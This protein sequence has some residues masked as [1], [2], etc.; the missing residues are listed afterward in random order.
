[1]WGRSSRASNAARLYVF[2]LVAMLATSAVACSKGGNGSNRRGDPVRVAAASDL[3]IAFKEVG[4]AF[5]QATGKKVDFSFGSTGLL[6]KQIAEGAPFDVFA[7]ANVSYVEDV[8]KASACFGDTKRVYAR[9]RLVIWSKD[10]ALLPATI[11]DLKDPKYAK[12]AIANPDHAPYGVAAQQALTKAGVWATVQP[13]VV[14]GENV[15]QAMMYAQS[16]N[17]EIA[18]IG[19][20]LAIT[21][22]G[23]YLPIDESLHAPLEQAMVIC[24]AGAAGAKSN[25]ARAFVDFVASEPARVIMRRYGF[26][27]PGEV[28][29]PH[30]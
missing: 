25:E 5:E 22:G 26:L 14:N 28:L 10:K 1:M 13:R 4:A 24:K 9:G 17:A 8:V 21:S 27:L 2:G 29:P 16:G 6:A 3:S 7:A 15:Q 20:S 18:V 11:D 23:G 12:I 19:L 30:P